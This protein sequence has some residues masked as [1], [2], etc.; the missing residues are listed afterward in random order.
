V[1]VCGD[2]VKSCPV[3]SVLAR[4]RARRSRWA[5]GCAAVLSRLRA[6]V[7]LVAITVLLKILQACPPIRYFCTGFC[8]TYTL[9]VLIRRA[10]T[11]IYLDQA[12]PCEDRA[13]RPSW[14]PHAAC[15]RIVKECEL[16]ML[17][18]LLI[19]LSV[20][21]PVDSKRSQP[22]GLHDHIEDD[23]VCGGQNGG[24]SLCE[25][26]GRI[27]GVDALGSERHERH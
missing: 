11:E 23:L 20:L 1:S 26:I 9:H 7:G 25:D 27:K 18:S 24:L 2:L 22:G 21:P 3:R 8:A 12:L 5:A 4:G 15:A 10:R 6:R 14:P 19:L 17:I 13:A 16:N